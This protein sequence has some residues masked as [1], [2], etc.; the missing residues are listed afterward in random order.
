MT[1]FCA[2]ELSNIYAL[3]AYAAVITAIT[4]GGSYMVGNALSNPKL[5]VWAKT[6]A[7]Q[8]I[9]SFI[10][11]FLIA[12]MMNV[13][14]TIDIKEIANLFGVDYPGTASIYASAEHYLVGAAAYAHNALKVVRYHLD[15]YTVLAYTG[16]FKCASLVES[17][18]VT[19]MVLPFLSG[20]GYGYSGNNLSPFGGYAAINGALTTMFNATIVSYLMALNYL[21]ILRYVYHGFVLFLLP[22]GIFTR[23]LPY[24]RTFGSVLIAVA[25]S[26]MFIY[27]IILAVFDIAG[28]SLVNTSGGNMYAGADLTEYTKEEIYPNTLAA[29]ASLGLSW[30]EEALIKRYKLKEDNIMHVIA[31]SAHAFIAATFLPSIALLATIASTVYLSRFYGEEVDLSRIMQMV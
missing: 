24:L 27:P 3:S 6:E 20:C 29:G 9:V 12:L 1:D 19:T 15:G 13:Y 22:I 4:I 17:G 28:D 25:L 8:L 10:T 11:L 5:T 23:S 31:F 30:D 16:A 21:F 7:V 26:F 14:C 18:P 2:F